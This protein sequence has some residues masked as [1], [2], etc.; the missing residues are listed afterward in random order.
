SQLPAGPERTRLL[1]ALGDCLEKKLPRNL[2]HDEGA[3]ASAAAC[4]NAATRDAGRTIA[5]ARVRASLA[6]AM[7]D[8]DAVDAIVDSLVKKDFPSCLGDA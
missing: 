2:L 8:P 4:A 5:E 3:E 1:A 6:G 7:S